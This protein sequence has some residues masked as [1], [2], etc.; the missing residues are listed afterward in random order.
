VSNLSS[1]DT[2]LLLQSSLNLCYYQFGTH[3]GHLLRN[4]LRHFETEITS[5]WSSG[6]GVFSPYIRSHHFQRLSRLSSLQL[7]LDNP[8]TCGTTYV[9]TFPSTFGPPSDGYGNYRG[10]TLCHWV[11]SARQ[12]CRFRLNFKS[13]ITRP[14]EDAL[15]VSAVCRFLFYL[16]TVFRVLSLIVKF[17]N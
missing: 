4:H 10:M 16:K 7:F 6:S 3:F 9:K 15:Y 12:Q 13:F 14:R 2:S 5:C 8:S 11:L 1:F 17:I